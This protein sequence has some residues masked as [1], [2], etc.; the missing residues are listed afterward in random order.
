MVVFSIIAFKNK[1]SEVLILIDR[2][3]Y[4]ERNKMSKF[5]EH[6]QHQKMFKVFSKKANSYDVLAPLRFL[7]E[8]LKKRHIPSLSTLV[9][10]LLSG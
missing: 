6:N 3:V 8:S 10:L 9:T 7:L 1:V 2:I 5:K 4:K